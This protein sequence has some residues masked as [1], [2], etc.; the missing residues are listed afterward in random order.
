MDS[1]LPCQ[2]C[3]HSKSVHH[4]GGSYYACGFQNPVDSCMNYVFDNLK[5]LEQIYSNKVNNNATF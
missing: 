2:N 5:F 4:V 3:G 1:Y